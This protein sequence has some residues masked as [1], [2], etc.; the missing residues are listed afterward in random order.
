MNQANDEVW[1]LARAVSQAT[2]Q[3]EPSK[4]P[5]EAPKVSSSYYN[6]RSRAS[7]AQSTIMPRQGRTKFSEVEMSAATKID[8]RACFEM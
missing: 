5:T 4:Q 6:E 3:S 1:K 2:A 7:I 8:E